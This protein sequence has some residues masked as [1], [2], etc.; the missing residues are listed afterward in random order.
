MSYRLEWQLLGR[1]NRLLDSGEIDSGFSDR[2]SAIRALS[3]FLQ[4]FAHWG[5]ADEENTWWA[6]RSPD[7]DLLVQIALRD[8]T[9]PDVAPALWTEW[10][11]ARASLRG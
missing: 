3:A 11:R 7:A 4:Q 10:R 8:E 1:E 2:D 5:R 6:R 9:T